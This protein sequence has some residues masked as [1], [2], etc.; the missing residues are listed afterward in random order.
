MVTLSQRYVYKHSECTEFGRGNL[1]NG[2]ER[3]YYHSILSQDVKDLLVIKLWTVGSTCLV[4][5]RSVKVQQKL[6]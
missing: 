2:C 6:F 1:L 4:T 3:M 5:G